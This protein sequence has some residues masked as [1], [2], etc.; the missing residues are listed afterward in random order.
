M[1][2][3]TKP[4]H[5]KALIDDLQ[6]LLTIA[7]AEADDLK[8]KLAEFTAAKRKGEIVALFSALGREVKDEAIAPYMELSDVQF[9][10]VSADMLEL[11]PKPAAHLFS[12]IPPGS[13]EPQTATAA[14][15]SHDLLNQLRGVK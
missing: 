11:K 6:A 1:S 10:A 2:A 13:G 7:K 5:Q 4:D 3:E 9:A 15:L 12:A 8:K 14:E